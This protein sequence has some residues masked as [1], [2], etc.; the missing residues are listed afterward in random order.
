MRIG[1]F[2]ERELDLVARLR[3]SSLA[4]KH[5]P[6]VVWLHVIPILGIMDINSFLLPLTKYY[7]LLTHSSETPVLAIIRQEY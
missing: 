6:E 2:C 3:I 5:L 4:R 7:E 1:G